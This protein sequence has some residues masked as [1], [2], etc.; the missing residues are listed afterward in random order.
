[1]C[2][3]GKE[4]EEEMFDLGGHCIGRSS[5]TTEASM[6]R[7]LPKPQPLGAP[8]HPGSRTSLG[9]FGLSIVWERTSAAGVNL[10]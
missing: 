2:I 10:L 1:M 6:S 4:E 5:Q 3:I 8:A 7:A 9:T